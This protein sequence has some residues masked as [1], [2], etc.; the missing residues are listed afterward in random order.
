M[1]YANRSLYGFYSNAG[2]GS[3]PRGYGSPSMFGR[4][5]SARIPS[6]YTTGYASTYTRRKKSSNTRG[7]SGAVRKVIV[8]SADAKHFTVADDTLGLSMTHNTIY[9]YNLNYFIVQG[10]GN[11]NRD[12]DAIYMSALKLRGLVRSHTTGNS[13]KYRIMVGW[14]G[15]EYSPAALASGNLTATEIFLPLTG[16]I[17]VVNGIVNPKAFTVL[18]DE[19]HD[20]NSVLTEVTDLN[21]IDATI[22]IKTKFYYQSAGSGYGKFKNLY[23][24]VVPFVTGGVNGTTAAGSC[25]LAADLIFKSL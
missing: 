2:Y 12:G 19:T 13:Y 23:L 3:G 15:E 4:R 6:K 18:Y 22:P 24:V 8:N 5:S 9:S 1:V 14:S 10:D 11:A 20:I 16:T 7:F 25:N 21:T 17:G